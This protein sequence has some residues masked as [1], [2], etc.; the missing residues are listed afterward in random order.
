VIASPIEFAVAPAGTLKIPANG[1]TNTLNLSAK[2][3]NSY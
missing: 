3:K 1:G 2:F